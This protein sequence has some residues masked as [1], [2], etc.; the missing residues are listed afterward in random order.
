MAKCG[1]AGTTCA[2][3]VTGTGSITVTGTG[4]AQDPYIVSLGTLDTNGTLAVADTAS[5]NMTLLGTGSIGD[6]Y[7]VSGAVL[8]GANVTVAPTTGQTI[9]VDLGTNLQVIN[10]AGTLAALTITLPAT[11]GSFLSEVTI[12]TTATLTSL[13]VNGAAGVTVAGAP[14]TLAA[15]GYFKMRLV[16]TVW[17]RVG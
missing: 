14:T 5:I 10:P 2:C 15:N 8:V 6:P 7:V 13:T 4:T 3:K 1:C 16:G 17:R 12:L 9:V 11:T